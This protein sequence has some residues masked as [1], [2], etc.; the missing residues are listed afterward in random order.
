MRQSMNSNSRSICL[1]HEYPVDVP[2][3]RPSEAVRSIRRRTAT[4]MQTAAAEKGPA[5]VLESIYTTRKAFPGHND[6]PRLTSETRFS[7][8]R[9]LSRAVPLRW[10]S[11]ASKRSL[12]A[13]PALPTKLLR[14]SD[15]RKRL[16]LH[17]AWLVMI[18]FLISL[19]QRY[20]LTFSDFSVS[21]A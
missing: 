13:Q 15:L 6:S 8:R 7:Q 17:S 1:L 4:K 19:M 9:A 16:G 5:A 18:Q 2:F 20:V 10:A 21:K 11:S 3:I 12:A 14:Q